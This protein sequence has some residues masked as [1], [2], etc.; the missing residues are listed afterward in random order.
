MSDDVDEPVMRGTPI[1]RGGGRLIRVGWRAEGYSVSTATEKAYLVYTILL[2]AIAIPLGVTVAYSVHVLYAGFAAPQLAK[3]V[4]EINNFPNLIQLMI[5]YATLFCGGV[6]FWHIRAMV[7]SVLV[8]GST[9]LHDGYGIVEQ[10]R[11]ASVKR[12]RVYLLL[13]FLVMAAWFLPALEDYIPIRIDEAV[14]LFLTSLLFLP[15][16]EGVVFKVWKQQA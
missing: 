6:I 8:R 11:R 15:V 10:R 5:Y 3:V 9:K 12:K 2:L 16:L 4:P 7:G 14:H 13:I 1:T